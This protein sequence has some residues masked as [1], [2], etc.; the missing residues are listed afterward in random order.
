M[1][2]GTFAGK[3]MEIVDGLLGLSPEER[4]KKLKNKIQKLKGERDE[5][6]KKDASDKSALR[7]GAI[8]NELRTLEQRLSNEAR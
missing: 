3:A 7:V 6:L 8:N 5:L 4:V 1:G 2:W